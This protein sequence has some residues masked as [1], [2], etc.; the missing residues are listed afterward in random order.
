VWTVK[1]AGT[2]GAGA[3]TNSKVTP[4][5]AGTLTLTATVANGLTAS[6][7]FTKDFMV[8]VNAAAAFVPV[9]GITGISTI[10]RV[11]GQNV[12]LGG[13]TVTPPNATNQTIVWSTAP[14]SADA[15]I[16]GTVAVTQAAGTLKL[17]ATIANGLTASTPYTQTFA[18]TV[19]SAAF[20]A[21]S[22]ITGV[23]T[24]AVT[25]GTA[26][27]L[28]G[29]TVEPSSATNKTIAWTASGAGLSS[30]TVSGSVTPTAAGTLTL[31]A[32]VA[33]G[34]TNGTEDYTKTFTITVSAVDTAPPANVSGLT[35]TPGDERV[36]LSWNDPADADLASIEVTW[37]NGGTSPQTVNKGVKTYTATG[38]T[39]GTAY[40]FTVKAVDTAGNKN[41]GTTATATPAAQSNL[42]AEVQFGQTTG[43]SD[44]EVGMPDGDEDQPVV[45]MTISATEKGTVYFRASK[46]ANQTISASGTDGDAVTV[47]TNDTVDGTAA[48][49]TVAVVA[50]DTRG[51]VFDGGTS[52][53]ALDVAENGKGSRKINITLNV[54]AHLTG[55]ALFTVTH[56]ADGEILSRVD[57][58]TPAA[59]DGFLAAF[60]WLEENAEAETEYLLRV[61]KEETLP[62][63]VVSLNNAENVTLRLRGA[64]GVPRVLKAQEASTITVVNKKTLNA[65]TKGF[66]QIGPYIDDEETQ[67]R[68]FILGD[69]I[70]VQGR[71]W[72]NPANNYNILFIPGYNATLILE[73]GSLITGHSSSTN[74][75]SH[76][77]IFVSA[78]NENTNPLYY[79]AV[80]IKG[81]SITDCSINA[82]TDLIYFNMAKSNFSSGDA[83][84]MAGDNKVTFNN[85][86][87][88][89]VMFK[90]EVSA[91]AL[92][93]KL[94]TGLT[95]P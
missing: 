64:G 72:S 87:N 30:Q 44:V 12:S 26:I 23:S 41:S 84:V 82:N 46:T 51:L 53:F 60:E 73:K 88:N 76:A 7:P 70:T 93:E 1:N 36:A 37:D 14:D 57:T 77:V 15:V 67:K 4:S 83:F 17:T 78:K 52:I 28:S 95:L 94:V 2:T 85:N 16:N 79:G 63:L 71:A 65:P 38:L 47:H 39:N 21:A 32:T 69:N 89:N 68:T 81:G 56:D 18:I 43:S 33:G 11:V 58:G 42:T 91:D 8:T 22:N 29:A 9:T 90:T 86:T 75:K 13:A 48:G 92:A 66:I 55:A 50:V 45:N 3:V 6:T 24:T 62:R 20:V 31:T 27:S 49:S 59:F 80:R 74:S 10:S 35:G 54:T 61:E 34:K 19:T 5:A 25:E 40:T